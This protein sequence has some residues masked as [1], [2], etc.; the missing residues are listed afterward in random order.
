VAP[1][2][3]V[4]SLL[5]AEGK[6]YNNLQEFYDHAEAVDVAAEINAQY[7][8]AA[9]SGCRPTHADSH[10]G[11]L[12]GLTGKPFIKEAY[13]LCIKYGLPFRLPKSKDF[14]I[15]RF[16]GNVPAG[17][18]KLHD[19]AVYYAE[20]AGIGLISNMVTNPFKV[21]E[22]KSYE[23]LKSF[24]LNVIRNLKEGITELFL[25][26][27]KESLR[28]MSYTEEWQKRIWEY[29]ILLDD[30][31]MRAISQEGIELVGWDTAPFE[32]YKSK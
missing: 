13:E 10:C 21:K 15:Q 22:I 29:R 27:S 25:H 24:Y 18:S 1:P 2:A 17:I 4:A 7:N 11:T 32:L 14:L 16:G 30:D 6:L 9:N 3:S 20:K 12:Y 28:F 31:M 19:E 26:P 8:F 23:N 5:D